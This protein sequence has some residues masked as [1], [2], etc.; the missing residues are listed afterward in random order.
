MVHVGKLHTSE[1]RPRGHSYPLLCI[2]ISFA[3]R[4][5]TRLVRKGTQTSVVLPSGSTTGPSSQKSDIFIAFFVCFLVVFFV[6]LFPPLIFFYTTCD[7]YYSRKRNTTS[8]TCSGALQ[9]IVFLQV[10][11]LSY[12]VFIFL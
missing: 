11:P 9:L 7:I 10:I 3:R 8:P 6:G 12:G 2:L 1:L 4:G 5:E